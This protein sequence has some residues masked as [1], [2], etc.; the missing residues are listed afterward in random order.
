MASSKQDRTSVLQLWLVTFLVSL[1]P[2]QTLPYLT[3]VVACFPMVCWCK[4][5]QQGPSQ[6]PEDPRGP[7]L[8]PYL[9]S[10]AVVA[11]CPGDLP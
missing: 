5:V 3:A 10:E 4:T 8:L 1:S 9:S 2:Q 11:S 6:P 7:G